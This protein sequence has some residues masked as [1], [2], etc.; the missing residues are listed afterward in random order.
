M[1]RWI[2]D[3][4]EAFQAQRKLAKQI[5]PKNFKQMAQEIRNLA[6]LASQLSPRGE[7]MQKLIRSVLTEMDR[8]T[9]LADRPEFR[10]LST[11]KKLLLRQ[12]LLE[13]KEQLLESIESAP[14]PTERLQ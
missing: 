4:Y 9:D 3:K 8:L 13:S 1:F 11:G 2:K 6:V 5:Q 10:K 14:S 7:D 12:G